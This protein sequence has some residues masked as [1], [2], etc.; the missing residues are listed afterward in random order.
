[1]KGKV[2][3]IVLKETGYVALWTLILSGVLQAVFLVIGMWDVTVLLGNLLGGGTGV[4]NFFL[5]GLTVQRA[6]QKEEKEAKQAMKA[7]NAIR[8]LVL[9]VVAMLG[10]LLPCF[11]IFATLIP[12]F[13]AR[14]AVTVRA[15]T[16]KN[17]SSGGESAT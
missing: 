4:L 1:M 5:L 15:F 14:I 13:F 17:H 10:A 6:V 8:T 3:P 7:S 11:H 12:L 16:D 9:F 2:D